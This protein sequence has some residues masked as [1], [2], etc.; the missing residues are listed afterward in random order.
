MWG[1]MVSCGRVVLGL[2]GCLPTLGTLG[3]PPREIGGA[4]LSEPGRA[5]LGRTQRVPLPAC[6][7]WRRSRKQSWRLSAVAAGASKGG[8]RIDNPP[9]VN[10]LPHNSSRRA[11]E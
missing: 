5:P 9:Q 8:R 3:H 10:N 1:R 2:L 7:T 11:K 4:R 6:P